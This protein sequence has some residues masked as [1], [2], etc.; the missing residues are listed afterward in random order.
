[1]GKKM[2]NAPVYFTVAQIRFNPILNLD[3][4]MSTIQP[5]MKDLHFPDYKQ[6]NMQR[7]VLPIAGGEV[8][9]ISPPSLVPHSRFVFG[10]R[11]GMSNFVLE[12][13]SIAF[14]TTAYDTFEV[15]SGKLFAGLK[16]IHG[17]LGL[18]FTERVGLRYLD[19]IQPDQTGES[20]SDYLIPE[21][22]GLSRSIG[23]NLEHSVSETLTHRNSCRLVSRVIIQ[24]GQ[25]G[26][27]PDLLVVAPKVNPRFTQGQ[28]LYAI[29]DS[30]AFSEQRESFDLAKLEQHLLVLHDEIKKSFEATITAHARQV[31]D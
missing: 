20:L 13:N 26:L 28:G 15:F 24:N 9:Q 3:G 4:Y 6:E 12:N 22:L 5:K 19:A 10:D 18:D 17:T 8:G 23:G 1:M 30:D 21:V 25:V 16:V 29:I 11:E 7:L 2:S 31:W 27:P 14:Q